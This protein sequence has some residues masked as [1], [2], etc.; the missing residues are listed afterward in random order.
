MALERESEDRG[1]NIVSKLDPETSSLRRTRFWMTQCG[2]AR[3][4]RYR[5]A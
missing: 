3:I 4:M 1:D 5:R 2:L